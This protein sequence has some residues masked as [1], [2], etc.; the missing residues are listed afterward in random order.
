[1]MHDEK[2][3]LLEQA[4]D[5]L[6]QYQHIPMRSLLTSMWLYSTLLCG[7]GLLLEGIAIFKGH[8]PNNPKWT[9]SLLLWVS[10]N[11]I[12][13]Y[14]FYRWRQRTKRN[15]RQLRDGSNDSP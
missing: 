11:P 4:F 5:L 14:V 12:F 8:L 9:K 3:S 6:S 15:C 7:T 1:M 10:V 2:P 13:G